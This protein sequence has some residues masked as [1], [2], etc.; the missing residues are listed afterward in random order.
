MNGPNGE[1]LP[2]PNTANAR[3]L[4]VLL[5][6]D[7]E[8]DALLLRRH[9][10][11]A[12]YD[13]TSERVET[14]EGMG[15]AL[16]RREWDVVISDY[17]LPNFD[18]P[19]ALE[20]LKRRGIDLPFIIISGTAGEEAAVAAMRAGAH[21]FL[22]KGGLARLAPVIERESR[23]AVHRRERRRAEDAL[24]DANARLAFHFENTP[25][26]VIEWG[27]NFCVT[28]WSPSAERL[29]GWKAEE[30]LGRCADDW[31]FV[32]ADDAQAVKEVQERQRRGAEGRGVSRNRNHA[33]DGSVLYCDWYN[34]ALY[35]ESGNLMSV[36]SLV[37][38]VTARTL[39]ERERARLLEAEQASRAEAER[40]NRLK[41][42]FLATVSHELRTPLTAILGWSSMLRLGHIDAANSADAVETIHRNAQAQKQ[43]IDDLLDVSRIVTGQL[44]LEVRPF[45]AAE[46]V[47]SAIES[48]R[49]AAA[50]KGVRLRAELDP[51]AGL[52]SGDPARMQQVAWN[53]LSNAV[54]YTP[55]GGV[56]EVRLARAD[57]HIELTVSDTGQGIARE[58]LPHVFD[59]FRQ[60]DQSV[61]RKHGGLGLGL[62]IVR[63]FVELQGG[64]VQ[65]ESAG[66]GRGATFTVKLPLMAVS[67]RRRS[68]EGGRA[69]RAA[70]AVAGMASDCPTPLAG[71][72][73]L[74]VDDEE[75]A[76]DLLAAV[77]GRCGA[78][79]LTAA[80]AGEALVAFGEQKPDVLVSDIGM[81]GED[82]YELIRKVRTLSAERG[83]CTPAL[84]LTAYAREEDRERALSSGYQA[85]AAKP[86]EPTELAA[87][88]ANLAGRDLSS[89]RSS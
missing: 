32:Y 57:S 70:P 56:V 50:A 48:V 51:R 59:R 16:D 33:K 42:E 15:D 76:R 68:F 86:V 41:D 37:L 36:L 78:E 43:L 25:L 65:A 22:A 66:L 2:V 61:T 27:G 1:E 31:R 55:K 34:S 87:A 67:D 53:L 10:L 30:V 5:I 17:A 83:G 13:L 23:E 44:R 71:M 77:L 19:A 47:E 64:T 46:A 89:S 54:K 79:V 39:A 75:D 4:R 24:R 38:D 14:A 45:E 21:D 52:V 84:A 73:V 12:G 18:A 82:G 28:R 3:A 40:A 74:V 80:S 9:L 62:A 8:D 49:P 29:F 60:A 7:S 26:A 11:R 72:R 6:E 81:P 20:L 88:V 58:F 63:H 69:S 35:D 85:H